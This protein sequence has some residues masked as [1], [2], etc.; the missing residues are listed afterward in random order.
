MNKKVIIPVGLAAA[1]AAVFALTKKKP[2]GKGEAKGA[3][4]G[5]AKS[6]APVMKNAQQGVYTF[7]S[8]YRDPVTVDVSMDYDSARFSFEV[9]EEDFITYTSDSHVAACY[10]PDFRMQL[11]YAGYYSGEDFAA[12][13]QV[14]KE[15]YSGFGEAKYGENVGFKYTDGD[16][17][18]FCFPIPDDEFSYILVTVL[19][20][21]DSKVEFEDLPTLDDLVLMLSSIK[22][23]SKK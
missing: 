2:A 1:G 13:S 17:L 18:C 15:K 8:G 4:K 12:Y 14:V 20:E 21:K 6:K 11:E 16:S 22:F 9:I 23:A 3:A 10:G 5:G 19:K 7:L